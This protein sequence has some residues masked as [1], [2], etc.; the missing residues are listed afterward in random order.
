M[1]ENNLVA[2]VRH[3]AVRIDGRAGGQQ[4]QLSG[5]LMGNT[6]YARKPAVC[7]DDE[8]NDDPVR[9]RAN[10]CNREWLPWPF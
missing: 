1:V 3:A 7:I 8:F 6:F 10:T 5:K 4:H 9:E 2:N